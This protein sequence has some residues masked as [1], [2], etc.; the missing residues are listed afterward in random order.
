MP[1]AEKGHRY[2]KER[3]QRELRY[4]A[5]AVNL[6]PQVDWYELQAEHKGKVLLKLQRQEPNERKLY[7]LVKTQTQRLTGV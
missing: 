2:A 4:L 5:T 7:V 3:R 1:Q 6:R